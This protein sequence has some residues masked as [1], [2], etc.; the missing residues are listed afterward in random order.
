MWYLTNH[1]FTDCATF[2]G[3]GCYLRTVYF[4]QQETYGDCMG[5]DYVE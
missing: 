5:K 3:I 2:M 1:S 4:Y